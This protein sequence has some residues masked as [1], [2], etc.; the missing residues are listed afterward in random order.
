M[1]SFE[2]SAPKSVKEA[3]ALLNETW[4]ET[5]IL[6]GGTDLVTSLKQNITTPKRVVSLKNIP[7]LRGIKAE[8]G[9]FGFP[10]GRIGPV[11]VVAILREDRLDVAFETDGRGR[12]ETLG[13]GGGKRGETQ[14]GGEARGEAHG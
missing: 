5:E 13:G 10:R 9:L 3:T 14:E 1:K 11:A 6:A 2:Y 7:E 12:G 8:G 4:G